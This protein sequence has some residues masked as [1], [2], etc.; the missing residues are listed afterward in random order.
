VFPYT[1]CQYYFAGQN[2]S[3]SKDGTEN[4]G[5]FDKYI[6]SFLFRHFLTQIQPDKHDEFIVIA[7]EDARLRNWED[8]GHITREGVPIPS[9]GLKK[10]LTPS[11]G[12]HLAT[13]LPIPLGKTTEELWQIYDIIFNV[14]PENSEVYFDITNA[15]RSLPLITMVILTYAK[16]VKQIEIKG[17]Y[18]GFFEPQNVNPVT[19]KVSVPIFDLAPFLSLLDWTQAVDEFLKTGR[20]TSLRKINEKELLPLIRNAQKSEQQIL[21]G[22]KK[23]INALYSMTESI[24][25]C[26]GPELNKINFNDFIES[27]KQSSKYY[28]PPMKPI[29]NL[30]EHKLREMNQPDQP[31]VTRVLL[32]NS[33][34]IVQLCIEYELVQQGYTLLLESIVEYV[35]VY[36]RDVFQ[37]QETMQTLSNWLNVQDEHQRIEKRNVISNILSHKGKNEDFRKFRV[38]PTNP[39]EILIQGYLYQILNE[40]FCRLY[41]RIGNQRNDIN[42]AAFGHKN[43]Q[44]SQSIKVDLENNYIQAKEIIKNGSILHEPLPDFPQISE[45]PHMLL[46]FSHMITDV[47]RDDA[48]KEFQI[49]NFIPFPADLQ[50]IWSNVPPELESIA[51]FSKPIKEWIE[52]SAQVGDYALLQ[53]DPGL[54]TYIADYCRYQGIYAVYATTHRRVN[55]TME[56]DGSVK[57]ESFFQHV[58]FRHYFPLD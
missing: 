20:M 9:Q 4:I 58:R 18:Y 19:G 21:G 24:M 43:Y 33:F 42:H 11:E 10:T 36:C 45:F 27:M 47:Q 2:F 25:T 14:I 57:K 50:Q 23:W 52:K 49:K 30:V 29:L 22:V 26:R 37:Q 8:N 39:Q 41:S 40:E 15:L 12:E 56:P 1:E 32:P 51:V 7:T 3:F 54:V 35:M 34:N 38:S 53:G 13:L 31:T 28:L 16:I 48:I 55:E 46:C 5:T 6:Q 44:N 17:L